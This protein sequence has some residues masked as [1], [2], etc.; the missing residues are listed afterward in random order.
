MSLLLREIHSEEAEGGEDNVAT[1]DAD[2][3]QAR[4]AFSLTQQKTYFLQ[5]NFPH[6]LPT[7]RKRINLKSEINSL[8]STTCAA[9][10]RGD[11]NLLL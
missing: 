3:F 11:L 2:A 9:L 1:L 4:N 10:H 6:P 8:A 5:I 7:P